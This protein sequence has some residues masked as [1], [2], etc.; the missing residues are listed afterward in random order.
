IQVWINKGMYDGDQEDG[1]DA[2]KGQTS[3]SPKRSYKR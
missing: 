3:K 2:E 1:A